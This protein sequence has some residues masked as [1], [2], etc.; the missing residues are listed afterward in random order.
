MSSYILIL[1]EDCQSKG[2]GLGIPLNHSEVGF[3]LVLEM[4]IQPGCQGLMHLMVMA[5]K[6]V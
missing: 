3:S 5:L 6:S 4:D 2:Q 1:E